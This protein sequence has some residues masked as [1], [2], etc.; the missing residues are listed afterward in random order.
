MK[1]KSLFKK[2]MVLL[3]CMI[4]MTGCV[5]ADQMQQWAEQLHDKVNAEN[6]TQPQITETAKKLAQEIV[7]DIITEDMSE[8]KK[9]ISIHDWLTFHLDY[10]HSGTNVHAQ[11]A[12]TNG[13][14]TSQGYAECFELMSELAGLEATMVAGLAQNNNDDIVK[15]V[16]NQVKIDGDWYNVD[17]TFDDPSKNSSKKKE[18]HSKNS[19]EYF[20]ITSEE[21]E[22]NHTAEVY[23]EEEKSC[24]KFHDRN[25]IYAF[26]A[27]SGLYGEV[28]FVTSVDEVDAYVEEAMKNGSTSVALWLLN[29]AEEGQS[30]SDYVSDFVKKIQ[31]YVSPSE[32]FSLTAN[33]LL[34]FELSFDTWEEW[35]KIP[36]VKNIE[37]FKELLDENGRLGYRTYLVRYETEDGTPEVASS[38][39]NCKVFYHTYNDEKFWLITVEIQE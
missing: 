35:E 33:G 2:I 1:K 22:K 5:S 4:T 15:H 14:T 8:V 38:K 29:L 25:E 11:E 34:C 31:F 10:D 16:W 19:Y 20:L 3:I 7:D 18:D 26:A 17:V 27:D 32:S 9:A 39:Y 28:K 30:V 13:I 37:E 36:V 12:L 21:L 6:H 24:N 23:F